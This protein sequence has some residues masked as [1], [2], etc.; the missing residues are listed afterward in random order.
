MLTFEPH[1]RVFFSGPLFRLTPAPVKAA[2]ALALG[3]D[4]SLVMPFD[5]ALAE[6]SAE[7]FVA[8]ILVRHLEVRAVATGYDFQFGKGR[9]GTPEFLAAQGRAHGFAVLIADALTEGGAAV[10]STRVRTA[11][12]SGDV[13]AANA[14]LGW[15]WAVSGE[16]IHGDARGR[17]LGYPT[18]N[19]ALDPACGLAHGIYAVRFHASGGV[20]RDG[21]ASWGRRP[22]FGGGDAVLETF[23]FDYAGD[24]YGEDALVSFHGFI[25]GEATFASVAELIARMDQDS[26]EARVILER[27]A[28]VDLDRR[29]HAI[30]RG[31]AP[32]E[33]ARHA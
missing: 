4:G 18:A 14:L 30:W 22:M 16:V 28:P 33:R 17:E 12:A 3:F 9:R 27:A 26:I 21:V 5:A 29:L 13:A 11:L 6:M 15:S 10:S 2:L 19:M 31:F 1:P 32:G 25:R 24:L 8:G 20:L 23:V 7:D